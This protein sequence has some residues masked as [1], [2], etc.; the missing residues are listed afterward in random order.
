VGANAIWGNSCFGTAR[1]DD[2]YF[3]DGLAEEIINRL[4]C[5]PGLK[6][7]ARTSA[8]SFKGK[9]EDIRGMAAALGV[10]NVLEGSVR[11]AGTRVRILTRLISSAD[12]SHLWSQSYDR[13]M[14]DIFDIQDDIAQAIASA[15]RV[16]LLGARSQYTPRLPTYEAYLKARHYMAAMTRQALARSI[17]SYDRAIALDSGFAAAHSGLAISY[18]SAVLPGILPG[19]QALPAAKAAAQRALALDPCCQEA[20]AVIGTVAALYDFDWKEAENAFRGVMDRE[21]VPPYVR[22]YYAY[23][24]LFPLCRLLESDTQCIRGL[25]DDPLNFIGGFQYAGGLLAAGREEEGQEQLREL[26]ALHPSLYQ[27]FYL[28]GLS[29]A[30]Q[31]SHSESLANAETAYSLAN[32]NTGAI[33]LLAGALARAGYS[34]RSEELRRKLVA[35][36]RY[37]TAMGLLLFH[38]VRSELDV[39][40]DWAWKVLQERDT[41]LIYIL[42]LLRAPSRNLLRSNER[43]S[44]IA[45]ALNI[46]LEAE[47]LAQDNAVSRSAPTGLAPFRSSTI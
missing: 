40:A 33:G 38:L 19:H 27:P 30:L 45:G 36:D 37:G 18:L 39:A 4:S 43:W 35:G 47:P 22:W 1:K 34:G 14:H 6:V 46:P 44:A 12:G 26:C 42:G 5:V 13:E 3:S 24:C 41:R 17:E 32:W 7:I 31:G 10:R 15:L 9:Q 2:E 25:K 8:F 21:P 20:Q 11:R 29:Q 16:Q 28:L 23:S